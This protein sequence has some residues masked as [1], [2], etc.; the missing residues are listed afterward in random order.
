MAGSPN[1]LSTKVKHALIVVCV[2]ICS[3]VV[4]YVLL[5]MQRPQWPSPSAVGIRQLQAAEA[6][7]GNFDV[8]KMIAVNK[9]GW[10]QEP[11]FTEHTVNR[12]VKR[13]ES[14][15]VQY[16]DTETPPQAAAC[17]RVLKQFN[18]ST[19][20]Y[21]MSLS[22]V[23]QM[24]KATGSMCGLTNFARAW[25]SRVVVPFTL[26]SELFSLPSTVD[27]PTVKSHAVPQELHKGPTHPLSMIYDLDKFNNDLLCE[28]YNLPPLVSFEEFIRNANRTIK[29]MHINF[30][31]GPPFNGKGYTECNEDSEVASAGPKLLNALNKEA[32][33]YGLAHFKLDG[34]ACCINRK[35]TIKTP[36]EMADGCGFSIDRDITIVFTIWQGHR[37]RSDIHRLITAVSPALYDTPHHLKD[38]YP[39]S[40]D[41]KRNASAFLKSIS[42]EYNSKLVAIHFRTVYIKGQFRKCFDMVQELLKTEIG[43]DGHDKC[44]RYFVD[45]GEFGSHFPGIAT[46]ERVSR[47]ILKEEHIIPIHYDPRKFNGIEDQG[48][49]AL[50]EQESIAKADIVVLV[51]GGSFQTQISNKIVENGQGNR[52]FEPCIQVRPT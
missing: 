48:F 21:V 18:I 34:H 29:L 39:L 37:T 30:Q 33:K 51:G 4:L 47:K 42:C 22:Y 19:T 8:K 6:A 28:K 41:I 49:V 25:H 45:Y 36:Q 1:V 40:E 16:I 11:L 17:N 32:D 50:V 38:S 31:K 12:N 46:G 15:H 5:I 24:T 3:A 35:R 52:L 44:Y 2:F 43:D 7:N 27:F 20:S 10:Y 26:N 14:A 13:E 9:S 23:E